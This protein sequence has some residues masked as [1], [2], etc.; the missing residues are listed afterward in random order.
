MLDTVGDAVGGAWPVL[1]ALLAG[2]AVILTPGGRDGLRAAMRAMAYPLL[3][4]A[5]VALI[6]DVTRTTSGDAGLVVTSLAEHWR[7]IAPGTF[8][9]ARAAVTRRAGGW[10]WDPVILGMLRL[11]AWLMLGGLGLGLGYAGR[12]RRTVNV[13]A[14]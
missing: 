7:A 9:A 8:D 13:F 4:L 11:P 1:V 10:M 2:A 3:L 12:R 5:A 14:N 6:T